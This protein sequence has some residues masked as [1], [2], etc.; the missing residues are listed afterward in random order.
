[1]HAGVPQHLMHSP[2]PRRG[3]E[4]GISENERAR[5]IDTEARMNSSKKRERHVEMDIEDEDSSFVAKK[6]KSGFF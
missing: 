1:M 2:P 6:R 4:L 5:I 3:L